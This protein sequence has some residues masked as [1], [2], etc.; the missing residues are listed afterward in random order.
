[1][2][3][4]SRNISFFLLL[5]FALFVGAFLCQLVILPYVFPSVHVGHGLLIGGDTLAFHNAAEQLADKIRQEGWSQW[6]LQPS[7]WGHVGISAIFYYYFTSSPWILIPLSSFLMALNILMI[8]NIISFAGFSRSIATISSFSLIFLPSTIMINMQ[9]H[10]DSISVISSVAIIFGY[11]YFCVNRKKILG[12]FGGG[13]ICILGFFGLYIVR[14]HLIML[15][16]VAILLGISLVFIIQKIYKSNDNFVSFGAVLFAV[17]LTFIAASVPSWTS[18]H[19]SRADQ[20]VDDADADADADADGDQQYYMAGDDVWR[21]SSWLPS[22]IDRRFALIA[23]VRR[24]SVAGAVH[25]CS[26]FGAQVSING[27]IEFLE[28][29]PRALV[30]SVFSPF[31]NQWLENAC[32]DGS[33]TLRILSGIEMIFAYIS[34]IGILFILLIYRPAPR[35]W[36]VV[37]VCLGVLIIHG[38]IFVNSGT[39]FRTRYAWFSILI[40]LGMA[41]WLM[42]VQ[43]KKKG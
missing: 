23:E 33:R 31:P 1:M 10:K 19:Q 18:I 20:R 42:L 9:W 3:R 14:D 17:F 38:F 30:Y 21:S 37:L 27:S 39:L 8:R 6:Q 2:E 13:L 11:V 35:V 16:V 12:V 5:W 4:F 29:L 40:S 34:F 36:F 25:G 7:G 32:S 41:G 26:N 43:R 28:F 24:S 15:S 22:F